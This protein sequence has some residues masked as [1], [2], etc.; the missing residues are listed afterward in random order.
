MNYTSSIQILKAIMAQRTK[1]ILNQLQIQKKTL[2]LDCIT[3]WELAFS[4]HVI[5]HVNPKDKP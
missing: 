3:E 4:T 2:H 1:C 5:L